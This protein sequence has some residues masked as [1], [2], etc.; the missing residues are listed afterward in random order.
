MGKWQYLAP[1]IRSSSHSDIFSPRQQ[2]TAPSYTDKDLLGTTKFSSMPTTF[3]NPSHSG[4]APKGLLKLNINS[5]GSSK[6]MLSASNLMENCL[7]SFVPLSLNILTRQEAPSPS[8]KAVWME[9]PNRLLVSSS[10]ATANRSTTRI[11]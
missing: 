5:F 3:P 11:I 10:S 9:S 7:I 8:Q 4:Q 2:M 6:F 1:A